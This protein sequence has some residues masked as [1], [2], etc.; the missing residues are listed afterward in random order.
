M[1]F[2]LSAKAHRYVF[3]GSSVLIALSLPFSKFTLTLGIILLALNWIVEGMWKKKWDG[4]KRNSA[5]WVFF[6]IYISLI[7]GIIFTQN[8][9]YGEQE[10]V[11]KLPLLLI[12][13]VYASSDPL[14]KRESRI[15]LGSFVIAVLASSIISS[16]TFLLNIRYVVPMEEL[17]PYVSHIRLAL[18]VNIALAIVLWEIYKYRPFPKGLLLLAVVFILWFSM[19]L[20]ILKSLTGIVVF[21]IMSMFYSVI[22]SNRSS[23]RILR[24][25]V[26]FLL[27]VLWAA[28]IGLV[29]RSAKAYFGDREVLMAENLN[30]HTVNG[31]PYRHWLDRTEYENGN[32]VWVNVCYLELEKE[33][34]LRSTIDFDE[35]DE[36]E[37][38][39]S[40]TLIRYLTSKGLTK[41]SIGV[42]SLTERDIEYVEQGFANVIFKEYAFGV[43]PRLYQSFWEIDQ[44]LSRGHVSGSSLIQRY[45]YV[46]AG[47]NIFLNHFWTGVGTGDLEDVF[48][49]YYATQEPNLE[50]KF[51]YLSHNQFLAQAVQTG[52]IGL[53]LFLVGW[54]YPI[55]KRFKTT[56]LLGWS[57]FIIITLS[58][59]NEDTFQTHVGV[60]LAAFFYGL[61]IFGFSPEEKT[62]V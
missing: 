36:Q 54:F 57:V 11:L 62:N 38:R 2:L 19:F 32:L 20:V 43:F 1:G 27:F 53:L 29:T 30:S 34:N 49:E 12:P 4:L 17:S 13:L 25:S 61:L 46:K 28:S 24:Y 41:D 6:S 42:W 50:Q 45:V 9:S 8:N 23:N 48:Y 7:V 35:Y 16:V 44:Y 55:F 56:H 15:I 33:W 58:M 22:F 39:I 26:L 37:Q 10:L 40:S 14:S 51:W 52:I 31:N 5:V 60:S 21:L 47:L 18:M 3:V 59:F